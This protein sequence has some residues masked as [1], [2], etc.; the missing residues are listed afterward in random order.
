MLAFIKGYLMFSLLC[1]VL[2]LLI[3]KY[4]CE[5]YDNEYL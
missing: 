3:L 5:D 4:D 1:N 2:F